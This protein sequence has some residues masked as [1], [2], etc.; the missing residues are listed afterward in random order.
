[1]H[2]AVALF[3]ASIQ[4]ARALTALYDFLT[5]TVHSPF[6]YDDLLRSQ[7]VYSVGAFDKLIHELVRIGMVA[8]FMGARPATAKYRAESISIQFHGA[9]LGA[10]IP[11]KEIL[12]EQE[13]G[14]KLKILSFQDPSK[15][16]DGL[17]YIWEEKDK[18]PKIAGAM[19][20]SADGAKTTMKLIAARRNAIVHESDSN[21]LS[22]VKNAI[23]RD[24]CKAITDFIE[25]CGHSIA[26]LVI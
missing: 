24:E 19:R 3:N 12:F 17:A 15:I 8:T 26:N 10:T 13:I 2:R 4:D 11:P 14:R 25:L 9:L 16:A 5:S 21:P 1:M 7:I 23:T 6:S 18:W 22:N 20:I